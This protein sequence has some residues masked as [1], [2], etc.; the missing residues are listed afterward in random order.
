M[1]TTTSPLTAPARSEIC[2]ALPRLVRA[3]AAVRRLARMETNMPTYPANAE[4]RAPTMNE[5]LMRQAVPAP[6]S[7]MFFT[8][9]LWW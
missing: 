8:S 9:R 6:I 5:M 3:A 7:A 1:E 2:R 4:H